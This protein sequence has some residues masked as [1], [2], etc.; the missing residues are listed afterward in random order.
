M[1]VAIENIGNLVEWKI[2]E[3]TELSIILFIIHIVSFVIRILI[4]WLLTRL[5][6]RDK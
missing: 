2:A 1:N 4:F 5:V 3:L 6:D